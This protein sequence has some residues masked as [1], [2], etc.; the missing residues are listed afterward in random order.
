MYILLLTNVM[1][2][3]ICAGSSSSSD[4]RKESEQ[5]KMNI[6]FMCPKGIEP[7]NNQFPNRH[8]RPLDHRL[9]SDRLCVK[10]LYY[11]GI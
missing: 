9:N 1:L 4:D 8:L 10:A 11:H 2:D 3:F 5:F 7:A 6:Q